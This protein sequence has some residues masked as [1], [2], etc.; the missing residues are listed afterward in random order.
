MSRLSSN[1]ALRLWSRSLPFQ[2][3]VTTLAGDSAW[4]YHHPH[5]VDGL[6]A[7]PSWAEVPLHAER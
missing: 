3:V 7:I 6:V 5:P 2:V 1:P 4:A